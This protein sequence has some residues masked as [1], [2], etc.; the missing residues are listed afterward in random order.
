MPSEDSFSK[1]VKESGITF[2]GSIVGRTL[3]FL[4]IAVVTRLVS[5]GVYGT[6]TLALSIVM[7]LRGISDLSIHRAIDY[8]LPQYLQNGKEQKADN[9]LRIG[10][11]LTLSTTGAT[12]ILVVVTSFQF[13]HIFDDPMLSTVLPFLAIVIPLATLLKFLE[14]IFK[15]MR[16]LKHRSYIKDFIKPITRLSITT[17]LLLLGAGIYGL[18]IGHIAGLAVAITFGSFLFIRDSN[19]FGSGSF[20]GGQI[21]PI[22]SYTFP[23]VFAGVIYAVVGYVDYFFIGYF[24]TSSEVAYYQVV[25]TLAANTLIIL[26]S[27]APVFKPT[28]AGLQNDMIELSVVFKNSTRWVTMFTLPIIATL[29]VAP[30]LY[31]STLFSAEYAVASGAF[32]ALLIGYLFTVS[33]G[34]E[35]MMLEGLGHTRLTLFNTIILI[36]INGILNYVFIPKFGILGAGMATATGLSITG[37][38]GM[39]EIYLLYRIHPY[40][41][42]WVKVT[43]GIVPATLVGAYMSS[44][45]TNDILLFVIVPSAITLCY[46]LILVLINGFTK[47]DLKMAERADK[48]LNTG[49][50][51]RLV[52]FGS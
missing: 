18:I 36:V 13:S 1:I 11:L 40:S 2:A 41:V 52:S 6:F 48:R 14:S 3:G 32:L 45:N 46:F 19:W 50:I 25:F 4:Y 9:T 43:V 27:V 17:F 35:G 21:R 8:F 47:D 10:I 31:I 28:V 5:P 23:L 15:G 51:K 30:D 22:L 16:I 20:R 39:I 37:A 7:L 12:A 34:L 42:D 26:K 38:A 49:I 29:A 24:L 33:F 44:F